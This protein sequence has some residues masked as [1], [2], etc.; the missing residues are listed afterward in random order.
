MTPG[1]RLPRRN[2][3]INPG[4]KA[5]QAGR[6]LVQST[7]GASSG[8]KLGWSKILTRASDCGARIRK[9][10]GRPRTCRIC[11]LSLRNY[12]TQHKV[13][14][15]RVATH[16]Q[17]SSDDRHMLSGLRRCGACGAGM[18]TNGKDNSGRIRRQDLTADRG[19]K[20]Y[21][22]RTKWPLQRCWGHLRISGSNNPKPVPHGLLDTLDLFYRNGVHVTDRVA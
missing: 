7:R 10:T 8:I 14:S 12:S 19:P 13:A 4:L 1:R 11:A 16:I 3:V 2:V 17:I 18:S 20:T 15:R 6:R 22:N 5:A 21:Q 9:T